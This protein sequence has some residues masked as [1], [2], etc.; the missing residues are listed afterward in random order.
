MA[1]DQPYYYY[2]Y[3]YYGNP[4]TEAQRHCL[5]KIYSYEVMSEIGPAR[6]RRFRQEVVVILQ[7]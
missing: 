2:N 4:H 7:V 1:G 3:Q 5:M 6:A